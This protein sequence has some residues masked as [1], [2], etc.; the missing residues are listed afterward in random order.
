M[1]IRTVTIVGVGLIGGSFA[2]ALRYSCDMSNEADLIEK[3]IANVLD[4]GLRTPDIM[5]SG[6]TKVGTSEMGAAIEKELQ[7]LVA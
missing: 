6:M 3:A 4:K 1:A 2:M 5:Q 7:A